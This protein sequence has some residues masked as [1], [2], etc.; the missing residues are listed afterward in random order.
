MSDLSQSALLDLN[1][2][3]IIVSSQDDIKLNLVVGVLI[4]PITPLIDSRIISVSKHSF[5]QV[6]G[7]TQ[8]YSKVVLGLGGETKTC[9]LFQRGNGR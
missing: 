1:L 6:K 7:C 2:H 4:S 3:A 9:D 8:K 5:T